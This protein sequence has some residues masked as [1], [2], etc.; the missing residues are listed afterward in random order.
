VDLVHRLSDGAPPRWID[1]F[2]LQEIYDHGVGTK[3]IVYVP[4]DYPDA[5]LSPNIEARRVSSKE[6]P[7]KPDL[8]LIKGGSDDHVVAA[9]KEKSKDPRR[10]PD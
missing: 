2:K 4:S 10:D 3:K 6:S 5:E 7:S 9:P 8:K 1:F